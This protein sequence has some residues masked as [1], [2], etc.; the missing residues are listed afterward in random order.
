MHVAEHAAKENKYFV[1]NLA[2]PFVSEFYST[3][4]NAALPYVDILFANEEEVEAY[5]KTNQLGTTDLKGI[6]LKIADME[7]INKN[8]PRMVI[9]TQGPGSVIVAS[10]GTTQEFDVPAVENIV[11]TNGAGDAFCGGFLAEFVRG[12]PLEKCINCACHAAATVIQHQGCTFPDKC[13][14]NLLNGHSLPNSLF[15]QNPNKEEGNGSRIGLAEFLLFTVKRIQCKR[16]GQTKKRSHDKTSSSSHHSDMILEQDRFLPIANIS[17]IMKRVIP[18]EGKLSKESK[19]CVQEC[20]SEFLLFI[21]SEASEK[22]STEKRKTI[23]GEDL[24]VAF[25]TLGFDDYVEPM[26]EFLHKYREAN[27]LHS[28]KTEEPILLGEPSAMS[29]GHVANPSVTYINPDS[30]QHHQPL[31]ANRAMPDKESQQTTQFTAPVLFNPCKYFS[32]QHLVNIM[33]QCKVRMEY[34]HWRA[35]IRAFENS[36]QEMINRAIDDWPRRLDA[37]IESKGGHFE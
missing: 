1:M 7:K 27:K 13:D 19:E 17:R 25:Q 34:P 24:I 4:L 31:V 32:I 22:C 18:S 26:K 29:S 9:V 37:V 21:T 23:T 20:I 11:D 28:I 2:A 6:A 10:K 5:S 14:Y 33:L 8:H 16:S 35:I 30:S 15:I 36:D 12:S 3:P